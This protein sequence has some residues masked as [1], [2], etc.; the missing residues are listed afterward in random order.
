[1][2]EGVIK[3]NCQQLAK[4]LTCIMYTLS[5]ILILPRYVGV[6]VCVHTSFSFSYFCMSLY[7]SEN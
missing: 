7:I 3:Y 1:M 5:Y 6:S 4:E 2:Y